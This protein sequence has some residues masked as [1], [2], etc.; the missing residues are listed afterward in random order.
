MNAMIAVLLLFAVVPID[1]HD[2]CRSY[3]SNRS[4][5]LFHSMNSWIPIFIEGT[6]VWLL[7]DYS[8]KGELKMDRMEDY[9]QDYG[10]GTD[11]SAIFTIPDLNITISYESIGSVNVWL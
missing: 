11:M 8:L 7:D 4:Q 1:G 2:F 10:F 6:H 3:E 9:E 5:M